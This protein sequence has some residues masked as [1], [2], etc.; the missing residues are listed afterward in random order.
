MLRAD[1]K[2]YMTGRE[3]HK[4]FHTAHQMMFLPKFSLQV[5]SKLKKEG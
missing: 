5:H 2:G 4:M 1:N 3:T